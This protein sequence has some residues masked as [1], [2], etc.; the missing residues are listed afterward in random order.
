[1]E[2]KHKEAV[3]TEFPKFQG[4]SGKYEPVVTE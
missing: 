4:P 1:M 3:E 2:D